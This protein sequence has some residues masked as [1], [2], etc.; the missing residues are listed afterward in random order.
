MGGFKA[1]IC[2]G[3][4][5]V[6]PHLFK[7]PEVFYSSFSTYCWDIVIDLNSS[8]PTVIVIFVEGPEL[9]EISRVFIIHGK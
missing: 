7:L 9:E 8:D 2:A 3:S 1:I 6:Y 4:E 5:F